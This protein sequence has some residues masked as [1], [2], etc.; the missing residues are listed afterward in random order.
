MMF[1]HIIN[2]STTIRII[3]VTKTC[4][5]DFCDNVSVPFANNFSLETRTLAQ[6]INVPG[7][8]FFKQFSS[9]DSLLPTTKCA[10]K[11][12]VNN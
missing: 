12:V 2:S 9:V 8:F 7:K 3:F 4:S 6:V 1:T 10:Y 11:F 5:H